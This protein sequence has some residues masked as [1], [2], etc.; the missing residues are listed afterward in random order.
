MKCKEKRLSQGNMTDWMTGARQDRQD[1]QESGVQVSSSRIN[2][3]YWQNMTDEWKW[4]ANQ[5]NVM[6]SSVVTNSLQV[7][8]IS[9]WRWRKT[10]AASGF[11][12]FS[13]PCCSPVEEV[14]QVCFIN[15]STCFRTNRG[16]ND[17]WMQ[18]TRRESDT[19]LK[20]TSWVL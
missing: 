18:N 12:P 13:P 11:I 16:K 14:C 20:S 9:W 15:F 4:Y 7:M 2:E 1:R 8:L 5:K 17:K 10:R 6:D 3:W 19:Q